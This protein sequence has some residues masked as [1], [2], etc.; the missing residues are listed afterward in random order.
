LID[1][2][3]IARRELVRRFRKLGFEGPISG[4]KQQFMKKADVDASLLKEILGQA[5][6]A[7]VWENL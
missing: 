6:I 2:E 1:G 5:D 3:T 7:L 4:G